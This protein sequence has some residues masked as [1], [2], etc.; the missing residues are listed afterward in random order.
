VRWLAI[1]AALG[2]GKSKDDG[3]KQHWPSGKGFVDPG[4]PTSAELSLERLDARRDGTPLKLARAF[5][6]PQAD[7]TLDVRVF[8]RADAT[9]DSPAEI[10]PVFRL[11]LAPRF[12]FNKPDRFAATALWVGTERTTLDD[13]AVQVRSARGQVVELPPI[14]AGTFTVRGELEALGC[15]APAPAPAAH[16]STAELRILGHPSFELRGAL[17]DGDDLVLAA[18]P[19][20]CDV[21][22]ATSVRLH[23]ENG[24]WSLDGAFVPQPIAAT[25]DK[26]VVTPGATGTGPDGKTIALELSGSAT[27]GALTAHLSGKIEALDCTH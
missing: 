20:R 11:V 13:V 25:N 5:I 3:P 16:P 14:A 22:P 15:Y 4:P 26:L 6:H 8:D 9:C 23:R 19:V 2:C 24:A 7:R 10:A 12:D 27:F 1:V 21:Q 17:R 18:Q